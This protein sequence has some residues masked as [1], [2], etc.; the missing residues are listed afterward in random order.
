[1]TTYAIDFTH[2]S[3]NFS[4]KHMMIS[5]I[6]GG[7]DSF[8]GHV[9]LEQIESFKN[10]EIRFDLDV[11]SINTR[12]DSRDHHLISADFFDADRYPKITFVKT[13]TEGDSTNF[14]LIGDLTIKDVTKEVVFD[15]IYSGHVKSPW[16]TDVY[17]FSC[18]TLL[19]RKKFNL[20]YNA[21]LESGG[22]LIGENAQINVE[23]E[24]NPL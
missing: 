3:I 11:A 12:D 21:A 5:K 7:F 14:K 1:M 10:A 17:G 9:Q 6:H 8:S 2:S 22:V 13:A 18:T 15:V 4:I 16:G 20:T 23:L 24:L 19:N